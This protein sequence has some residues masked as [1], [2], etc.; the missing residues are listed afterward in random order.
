ML[1]LAIYYTIA[2]VVLLAQCF[3][4]RGFTW[5]DEVIVP[6]TSD[7]EAVAVESDDG[8]RQRKKNKGKGRAAA[9]AAAAAAAGNGRREEEEEVG[10]D[11][12]TAL[13]LGGGNAGVASSA[14]SATTS[15][16][17]TPH[18]HHNNNNKNNNNN[19][20][21]RKQAIQANKHRRIPDFDVGVEVS[22]IKKNWSTDGRPS[23][24]LDF[25][26]TRKVFRII[27]WDT[28]TSWTFPQTGR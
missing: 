11:E 3:Y 6:V 21:Q 7:D 23:D 13:L 15:A 24:K 19:Q 16:T 2:D 17:L 20:A 27:K 10:P 8:D 26:R 14:A 5:R 25:P 28:L 1:I 22:I 4:Y 18:H 9:A 12:R